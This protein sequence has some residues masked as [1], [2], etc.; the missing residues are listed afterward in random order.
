M[1]KLVI[2]SFID[3]DASAVTKKVDDHYSLSNE[4][5]PYE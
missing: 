3:T 1:I 4:Y 2:L 5:F